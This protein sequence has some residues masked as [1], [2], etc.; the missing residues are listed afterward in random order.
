MFGKNLFVFV[1]MYVQTPSQTQDPI[2]YFY[3]N[4]FFCVSTY[5][6]C[7]FFIQFKALR[8]HCLQEN[9]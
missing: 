1:D 3:Q 7:S 4:D 6:F 9:T 8:S 5:V 2:F